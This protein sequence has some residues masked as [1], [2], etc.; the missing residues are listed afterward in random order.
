[1]SIDLTLYLTLYVLLFSD[2]V[3]LKLFRG[4]IHINTTGKGVIS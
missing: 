1:M 4:N 3:T 2:I